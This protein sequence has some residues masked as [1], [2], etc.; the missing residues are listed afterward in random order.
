[1]PPT[2]PPSIAPP[3]SSEELAGGASGGGAPSWKRKARRMVALLLLSAVLAL[4]LDRDFQR[5]ADAALHHWVLGRT[6]APEQHG[7]L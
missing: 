7:E 3:R 4:Y 6:R 2:C 5:Q 1:M